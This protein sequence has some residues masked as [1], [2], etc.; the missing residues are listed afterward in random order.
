MCH[1]I[2]SIPAIRIRRP[3]CTAQYLPQCA[4]YSFVVIYPM[5]TCK[6]PCIYHASRHSLS[7]VLLCAVNPVFCNC[8]ISLVY[9]HTK[10]LPATLNTCH[11][12]RTSPHAAVKHQVPYVRMFFQT[13]HQH[14][15]R[16]LILMYQLVCW[17]TAKLPHVRY[18]FSAKWRTPLVQQQNQLI[19][20]PKLAS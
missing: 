1:R 15:Y 18:S 20:L 6:T 4:I 12:N 17:N 13:L 3:L 8:K 2:T 16:F 11:A 19:L 14:V 7:I 9:F 10:K 5:R